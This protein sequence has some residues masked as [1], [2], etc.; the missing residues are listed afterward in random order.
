M[1]ADRRPA[2][3]LVALSVVLATMLTMQHGNAAT[4]DVALVRIQNEAALGDLC[5]AP[6][7]E[8][9]AQVAV[10][11]T[12]PDI[13][14][15]AWVQD[16][17]T[18]VV[19]ARS[20]DGGASWSTV[21]IDGID[22]CH[23]EV[24]VPSVGFVD[25]SLAYGLADDGGSIAYLALHYADASLDQDV[26]V[27]TSRDDGQTWSEP[28]VVSD[29]V[30]LEFPDLADVTPHPT[31]PCRAHLV[32]RAPTW[33]QEA[34]RFAETRD[35]GDSWSG[36]RT[37]L[38]AVI[39]R[40]PL[41]SRILAPP[42]GDLLHVFTASERA[43]YLSEYYG[44]AQDAR[45]ASIMV[46]RS[47]DGGLSWSDPVE[48]G[49]AARTVLLDPDGRTVTGATTFHSSVVLP[50]GTVY[51]VWPDMDGRLLISQSGDTGETWTTP[52]TAVHQPNGVFFPTLAAAP[53]G[54]L[55]IVFYDFRNDE[56]NVDGDASDEPLTTDVWFASLAPGSD[57]WEESH[58]AGPFDA[59]SAGF[60]GDYQGITAV[61]DGFAAAFVM[62]QPLAEDGETDAFFARIR[63]TARSSAT[64]RGTQASEGRAVWSDR[65]R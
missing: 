44:V 33:V 2:A 46:Q 50:D 41:R 37:V 32:W 1:R 31:V 40:S 13:V 4:A 34:V 11:P 48:I 19:V 9:E 18:A 62:S 61:H 17:N 49:R 22:T 14:L 30:K 27:L 6:H 28:R 29:Q 10:D 45:P 25:P 56:A 8:F 20:T 24:D 39:G 16:S 3:V 12:Q 59:R 42:G 36:P 58:V 57:T 7:D 26:L 43:A 52:T 65:W 5:S 51:V 35:C 64:P 60:L 38:P 63:L 47:K 54:T 53:D 15:A 23:I 55:G 21:N